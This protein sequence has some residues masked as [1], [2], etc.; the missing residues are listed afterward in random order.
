MTQRALGNSTAQQSR[1][2]EPPASRTGPPWVQA[3]HRGC[4]RR[5]IKVPNCT[6]VS[7][8]G[9]LSDMKIPFRV[10]D[11]VIS[12]GLTP[13]ASLGWDHPWPAG[14][15][16]HRSGLPSKETTVFRGVTKQISGWKRS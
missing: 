14:T 9:R 4:S 8:G 7:Q 3:V 1:G 15:S 5:K 2:S 16:V 13:P 6:H 10:T 11:A 12:R